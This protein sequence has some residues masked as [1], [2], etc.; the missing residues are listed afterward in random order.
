MSTR[1][2]GLRERGGGLEVY[3]IREGL[4]AGASD[5]A[6]GAAGTSNTGRGPG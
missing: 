2:G 1:V 4:G 3:E 5:I 6:A